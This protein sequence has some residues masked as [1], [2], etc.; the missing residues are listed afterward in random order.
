MNSPKEFSKAL[1]MFANEVRVPETVIAD[2]HGCNK[3]QEVKQFCNKIR[4]TMIILEGSTQRANRAE[5]YVG[6]FKEAA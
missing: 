2:S 5:V 4:T 3:S 6:V 1:K